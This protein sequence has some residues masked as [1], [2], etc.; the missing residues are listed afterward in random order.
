MN[1]RSFLYSALLMLGFA[2]SGWGDVVISGGGESF[3]GTLVRVSDGVL[4]FRTELSGQ[5]M[6]PMD[7][8]Q[9]LSTDRSMAVSLQDG[10]ILYG[11]FGGDSSQ[12]A[13][14]PLQ[15]G[16]PIPIAL[17]Q[18]KE[19]LPIPK[20]AEASAIPLDPTRLEISTELGL[21]AR[22][23]N[24]DT[25]APTASLDIDRMGSRVGLESSFMLE[26][27]EDDQFPQAARASVELQSVRQE[28]LVP[29]GSI[30]LERDQYDALEYR[31][32]VSL[33]L[34]RQLATGESSSLQGLLGLGYAYEDWN[35]NYLERSEGSRFDRRRDERT[36]DEINLPLGLRYSRALFGEGSLS[37]GLS[38]YP[39]LSNLG[40]LRAQSFSAFSYPLSGRL[41]LRLNLDLEYDSNPPFSG[42]E[43]LSTSVGAGIGVDF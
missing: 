25:L 1:K 27:G 8:V 28:G 31:A 15:P 6:M 24:R 22:T 13:L 7:T 23:G 37:T 33:G 14:F 29:F 18:I 21:R 2:V 38:V 32:Q 5:M 11:T 40:E 3:T 41:R 20:T 17:A 12:P 35:L 4:V 42:M 39:S 34:R 36:T 30:D 26:G 10:T 9:G 16:D 43:S 19:A